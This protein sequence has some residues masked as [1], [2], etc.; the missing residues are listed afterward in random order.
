MIKFELN[1]NEYNA[2]DELSILQYKDESLSDDISQLITYFNLEYTWDD[3]FKFDDVVNRIKSGHLLFILYYGNTSIGYV[4]FE[5]K[6][7]T[8]FYLYNLYVTNKIKRPNYAAQWFV[9]KSISL[10]PKTT[11]K[12]SCVCEDWHKA[13]HTTF[14]NNGFNIV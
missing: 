12:I 9:N 6:S 8:E 3:M 11:K 10:L 1:I 5:P 4:F 13:A 7:D 14:K 2:I